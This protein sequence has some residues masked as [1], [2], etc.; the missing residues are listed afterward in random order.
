[1]SIWYCMMPLCWWDVWTVPNVKRSFEFIFL[2]RVEDALMVPRCD[3]TLVSTMM[4]CSTQS[5]HGDYLRLRN[6]RSLSQFSKRW[7]FDAEKAAAKEGRRPWGL[8]LDAIKIESQI[9]I[10]KC[11]PAFRYNVANQLRGSASKHENSHSIERGSSLY[12]NTNCSAFSFIKRM[13]HGDRR[14][15]FSVIAIKLEGKFVFVVWKKTKPKAN[16]LKR[17]TSAISN[18]TYANKIMALNQVRT[19]SL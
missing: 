1:M 12:S 13:L 11:V 18:N 14:V 7:N 9:F 4:M 8:V 15:Q 19:I 17:R 16:Y 5:S 3:P 10:K 6:M 2:E